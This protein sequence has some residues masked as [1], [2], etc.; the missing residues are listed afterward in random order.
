MLQPPKSGDNYEF[1]VLTFFFRSERSLHS[2]P[3]NYKCHVMWHRCSYCGHF[4]DSDGKTIVYVT[5]Q[6]QVSPHSKT[7]MLSCHS[8]TSVLLTISVLPTV[9]LPCSNVLNPSGRPLRVN[10]TMILQAHQNTF[11]SLQNSA[12]DASHL[13]RYGAASRSKGSPKI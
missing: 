7:L 9:S 1:C 11:L 13:L 3:S 2:V 5:R 10:R 8:S 4:R 12:A 6:K